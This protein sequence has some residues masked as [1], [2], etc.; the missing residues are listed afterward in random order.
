MSRPKQ[1]LR[2]ESWF[3]DRHKADQTA[4]HLERYLNFG[5]TPEELQTL[6]ITTAAI[7]LDESQRQEFPPGNYFR[8]N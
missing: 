3:N 8:L 4:L 1:T 5:L 6:Y 7:A 2:S